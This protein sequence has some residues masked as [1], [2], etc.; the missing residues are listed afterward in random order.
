[1]KYAYEKRLN[2]RNWYNSFACELQEQDAQHK[3]QAQHQQYEGD[4]Q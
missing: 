4:E 2:Y 3:M 1:M